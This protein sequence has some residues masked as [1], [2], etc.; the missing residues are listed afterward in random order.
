M[1]KNLKPILD[2]V[3]R[4]HCWIKTDDGPRRIDAELDDHRVQLHLDGKRAFGVCPIA[5]GSSTTRLALFD[6]DSHRGEV[7]WEKMLDTA[8]EIIA[9]AK[10][11]GLHAVPFRSSGGAGVHLFFMWNEPQDA[12]SVRQLMKQI[13][14]DCLLV[15][16]TAGVAQNEIEI[17]PKQSSVPLD[18]FGSMFVLPFAGKSVYLPEL[19]L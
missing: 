17:F 7:P 14:D 12:Y 1:E 11:Y 9:A 5:P 3:W 2:R 18:G 6:L 19:E 10:A 15:P 4:G 8:R 13:L 16:G